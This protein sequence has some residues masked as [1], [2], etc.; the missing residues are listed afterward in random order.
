MDDDLAQIAI[1]CALQ[2]NWNDAIKN[3]LSIL[4]ENDEDV[5][6][7]NR[8]SRAYFENGDITKAKK[9]SLKVLKISSI[10]NIAIN[11]IE[12]YKHY[13]PSKNKG[14]KIEKDKS[15]LLLKER[16]GKEK[17]KT[18]SE[19]NRDASTF[20]EEPGKTKLTTLINLGPENV[21]SLLSAGDKVLITPYTHKV[22]V[23]TT[24]GSYIG[25]LADDLS[26]RLRKLI[27][28]GNKYEVLVKSVSKN[29]VKVFIKETKKG[30][31]LINT[32]SF[33]RESSESFDEFS[34]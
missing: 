29:C 3:N 28:G 21:Y 20:I 23:T 34:T 1:N 6:A 33:P 10:N 4:K 25:K 9:T 18:S 8:L 17:N 7:L 5:D 16:Q 22:S 30:K 11:A 14:G 13:I 12:K 15:K 24:T 32:Q 2:C 31:D 26:A 19:H 27:K